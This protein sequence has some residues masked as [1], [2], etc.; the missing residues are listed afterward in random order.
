MSFY[1]VKIMVLD[2]VRCLSPGE[3]GAEYEIVIKLEKC[4]QSN[5][6]K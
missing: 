2:S 1:Y 3:C 5:A 6:F 4:K